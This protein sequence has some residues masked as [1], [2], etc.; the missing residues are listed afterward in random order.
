MDG[1][2]PG[3]DDHHVKALIEPGQRRLARQKELRR[4]FDAPL[5]A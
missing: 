1:L 5:L 3:A 2:M 4:L